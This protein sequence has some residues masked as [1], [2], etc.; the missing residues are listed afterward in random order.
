MKSITSKAVRHT[1]LGVVFGGVLLT[2]GASA[3]FAQAH[4]QRS[5]KQQFKQHQ[6]MERQQY[7]SNGALLE[8]QRHEKEAFKDE[9]RH[10]RSGWYSAQ[11]GYPPNGNGSYGYPPYGSG[12]LGG[13]SYPNHQ[14]YRD[15]HG[16]YYSMRGS[17][18]AG[19]YR[20]R[21]WRARF[22]HH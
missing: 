17:S 8:H 22:R 4:N 6:R 14:T 7:G 15:G 5:E 16:T 21:G 12:Y 11:Y 20:H 1:A 19:Q 2:V 3:A 10:E 9:E 13:G 18:N